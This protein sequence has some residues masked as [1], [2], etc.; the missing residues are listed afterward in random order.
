MST[1][2]ILG[3]KKRNN[4]SYINFNTEYLNWVA[5]PRKNV[6]EQGLTLFS[7]RDAVLSLWCHDSTL[8]VVLLFVRSLKG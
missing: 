4:R 1:P 2:L 8:N 3:I 5:H 7:G 6:A